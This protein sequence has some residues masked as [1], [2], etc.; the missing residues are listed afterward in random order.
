MFKQI[1]LWELQQKIDIALLLHRN[2]DRAVVM[3]LVAL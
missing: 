1:E 3:V 2:C